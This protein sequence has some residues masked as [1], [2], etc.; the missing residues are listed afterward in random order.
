MA[1]LRRENLELRQQAGYWRSQH[2]VAK[3]QIAALEQEVAQ[4]CGENRKHQDQ[5]FGRKSETSSPTDRSNHLDEP[6]ETAPPQPRGQRH[7]RPGPKRRDYR[8]LP[9]REEPRVLPELQRACP[10]CGRPLTACVAEVSEQVEIEIEAYRRLIRRRRYQRTC[11]CPGPRT[12]TAP[13]VP[14][15]IPKGRLGASVRVEILHDKFATQRPTE[16]LLQSWRRLGLNLS[17]GTVTE[18]LHRLEPLFVGL[19]KALITRNRQTAFHQADETRWLVFVIVGDQSPVVADRIH[20]S[21]RRGRWP[22]PAD[23]DPFLPWNR[24]EAKRPGS[25]RAPPPRDLNGS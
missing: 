9:V 10:T 21:L 22:S 6:D 24:P 15:L 16:R 11:R 8:H 12:V 13:A 23:L 2:A 14:E 18:G 1:Q 3:Q 5:L 19:Y 7:D 20:A 4:L 17:A 25:K